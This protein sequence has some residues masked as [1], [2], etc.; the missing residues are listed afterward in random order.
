MPAS[1]SASR[2]LE[3]DCLRGLASSS[4]RQARYNT[5][6]R[7]KQETAMAASRTGEDPD[8]R[9]VLMLFAITAG[10]L[11]PLQAAVNSQFAQRGATVLWAAAI[12]GA[13]TSLT[14][15]AAALIVWRA[16]PPPLASF[17]SVPPLSV[18]GRGAGGR[19]PRHDDRR[20][21]TA[22]G[23]A[24]V[25]LLSRRDYRVLAASRPVRRARA[26]AAT[27]HFGFRMVGA[28]PPKG[29]APHRCTSRSSPW[30]AEARR[31]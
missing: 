25:C 22:R 26:A 12:S 10:A 21:A 27:A 19:H 29:D 1:S 30:H 16:P 23:G 2:R 13:V 5:F 6:D 7:Y 14:L 8:V 4:R 17:A 3:G 28:G 15:A 20:R 31:R 24:D 11:Q 18:D 9:M